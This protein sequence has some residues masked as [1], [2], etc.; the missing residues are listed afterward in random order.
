MDSGSVEAERYR[1]AR[2]RCHLPWQDRRKLAAAGQSDPHDGLVAQ[3]LDDL[4]RAVQWTCGIKRQ[5]VRAD[6]EGYG[7]TNMDG[8]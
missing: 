5:R 2:I 8:S 4:H 3:L 7:V 1:G 6:S